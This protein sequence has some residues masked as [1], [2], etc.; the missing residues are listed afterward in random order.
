MLHPLI[1]NSD[2][3]EGLNLFGEQTDI[4]KLPRGRQLTVISLFAG[5]GGFS[6]GFKGGFEIYKNSYK[7]KLSWMR[8]ILL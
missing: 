5:C 6:L 1:Q 7:K 4:K 2:F 3:D 8:Q